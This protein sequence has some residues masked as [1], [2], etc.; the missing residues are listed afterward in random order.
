MNVKNI[1]TAAIRRMLAISA[2]A[3]LGS[4]AMAQTQG[5]PAEPDASM[6]VQAQRG[7]ESRG[8]AHRPDPKRIEQVM[9]RREAALKSK[10]SITAGQEDAWKTWVAAIKPDRSNF[11]PGQ[12]RA[13]REA[14]ARL[15]TPERID[16]MRALKA[17]RDL[18]ERQRGDAT[19][20]FYAS[21]TPEQQKVFDDTTL[22]HFSFG[23]SPAGRFED[24]GPR[25]QKGP[26]GHEEG[27]H[28]APDVSNS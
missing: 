15:T 20:T 8:Q 12:M 19:K 10:L 21:L 13:E 3:L 14:L 26:R 27:K 28:P 6:E 25:G 2:V 1:K 18:T 5:Q 17:Q 23:S 7:G 9:Q 16:R 11:K 4:A 24:H 22:R